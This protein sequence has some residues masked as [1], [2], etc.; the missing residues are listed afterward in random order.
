MNFWYYIVTKQPILPSIHPNQ[1]MP[2]QRQNQ[3][4]FAKKGKINSKFNKLRHYK[5]KETHLIKLLFP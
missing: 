3:R 2:H 5:P 4:D 1:Q